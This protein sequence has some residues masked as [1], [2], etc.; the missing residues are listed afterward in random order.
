MLP[1]G[2]RTRGAGRNSEGRTPGFPQLRLL[3]GLGVGDEALVVY[4]DISPPRLKRQLELRLAGSASLTLDSCE[5]D[6]CDPKPR[7][8]CYRNLTKICQLKSRDTLVVGAPGLGRDQTLAHP[9][10]HDAGVHCDAADH[11]RLVQ[12]MVGESRAAK[13][14]SS[15]RTQRCSWS[16][17]ACRAGTR[18]RPG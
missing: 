17:S 10:R 2:D 3:R 9:D 6:L 8:Q 5:C 13:C 16:V 15:R 7:I 1:A 18:W 4:H 12:M 11:R 14:S